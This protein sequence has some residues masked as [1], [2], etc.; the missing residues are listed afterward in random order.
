MATAFGQPLRLT[1]YFVYKNI[2]IA[3]P[4]PVLARTLT[5]LSMRRFMS[6]ALPHWRVSDGVRTAQGTKPDG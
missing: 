4:L 1:L 2:R 3:N 6:T 5:R